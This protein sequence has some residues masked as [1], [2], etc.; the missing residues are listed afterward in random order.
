MNN[1]PHN[2]KNYIKPVRFFDGWNGYIVKQEK[3]DFVVARIVKHDNFK[4]WHQHHVYWSV[5][6]YFDGKYQSVFPDSKNFENYNSLKPFQDA[7]KHALAL[8]QRNV[9]VLQGNG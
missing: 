5:D 9:I 4:G 1:N 3:T 2:L 7:K 6:P 8:P